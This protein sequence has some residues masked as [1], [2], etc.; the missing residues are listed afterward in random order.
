MARYEINR[1]LTTLLIVEDQL[2][3]AITLKGALERSGYQ[4]LELALRHQEALALARAVKP[5]LALVNID[6]AEGD[7]GIALAGDLKAIDVPS[8]FISGQPERAKLAS[9]VGIAS[10][11]KP[12]GSAEMVSAVD[13]L[14]RR[15]NGDESAP[16]PRGLEIFPR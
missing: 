15:L 16:A 7:D 14:I 5:N 3:V 1:S 9:Q 10:M 2:I 11:P 8:V 6:L 4:V 13:C 12:Y